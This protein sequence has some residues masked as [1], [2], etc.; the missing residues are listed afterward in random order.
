MLLIIS[1][2]LIIGL[3]LLF[4]R[5]NAHYFR[6]SHRNCPVE[7]HRHN[8]LDEEN[9]ITADVARKGSAPGLWGFCEIGDLS[10]LA[11][12]TWKY[13]PTLIGVIYG[14][15]WKC[16]DT[17][18]KRAEPYYQLSQGA[19]GALAASSL[20]IEYDTFFSL[21]VPF[22]ALRHRQWVSIHFVLAMHLR[23]L[24]MHVQVVVSSSV[25]SLLAFAVVPT[26]LSVVITTTPNQNARQALINNSHDGLQQYD[27]EKNIVIDGRYTRISE[28]FLIIIILLGCYVLYNL[29]TRR[30]GLI[31][32]PSGI[33]GVAAMANKSHILMDFKELDQASEEKIHKQLNKRTYILHKGALWQAQLLKELERDKNAP[34]AMNAHPL[35]LRIKGMIPF[36]GFTCFV[37][38]ITPVMVY[39][40]SWNTIINQAPWFVIGLSIVIKSLWEIVEKDIRMLE[41]FWQL[42]K[43]NADSSVLTLDYTATIP[44]AIV[45]K[46]LYKGHFLLA[47]VAIVTLLIE[48]LTVVMGSLDYSGPGSEESK[49]SSTLS[50][51]LTVI[52]LIILLATMALLLLRRRHTFLPRQPGTISSVLAFIHQS[53]MLTDFEGTE[54]KTTLQR[55]QQL[56]KIGKTY[57]FGW[58]VGRDGERHLGID[59]EELLDGYQFGKDPLAGVADKPGSWERYDA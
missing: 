16:T 45:I 17:A 23:D 9:K 6:A 36:M 21:F 26:L 33:A 50:F 2:V 46:A 44:G 13:I 3:E 51:A 49:L 52:I 34:K 35:L 27:I 47:W 39:V 18:V 41:P 22:A 32:D 31:G 29:E 4:Q 10:I 37:L 12:A 28:G 38:V 59:Q 5:S 14:I 58:F 54:E 20:N 11:F 56:E 15:L 1:I 53:K 42:Y 57:G 30:S 19:K 7:T 48:I 8:P 43:R 40:K 25:A 55:R 24:L